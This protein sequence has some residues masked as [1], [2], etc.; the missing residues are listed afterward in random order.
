MAAAAAAAPS[1]ESGPSDLERALLAALASGPLAGR[2]QAFIFA[3]ARCEAAL[4]GT[5]TLVLHNELR[6]SAKRQAEPG[7]EHVPRAAGCSRH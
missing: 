3:A 7:H 1:F 6:N 4:G 5:A 2:L